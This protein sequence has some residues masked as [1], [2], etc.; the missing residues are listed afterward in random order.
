MYQKDYKPGQFGHEA[1]EGEYSDDYPPQRAPYI[2][3]Y[4]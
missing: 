1:T 2:R 3:K 4:N